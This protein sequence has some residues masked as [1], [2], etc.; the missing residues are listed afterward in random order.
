MILEPLISFMIL[1]PLIPYMMLEPH[2]SF[3]M[4]ERFRS[5]GR[6]AFVLDIFHHITLHQNHANLTI[7]HKYP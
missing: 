1:E 6:F 4:L 5:E 3:M 7:F 2:I